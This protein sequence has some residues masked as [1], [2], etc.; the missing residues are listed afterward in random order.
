MKWKNCPLQLYAF[1][2]KSISTNFSWIW[3]FIR[4]PFF[5]LWW[6][7]QQFLPLCDNYK[8]PHIFVVRISQ[9]SYFAPTPPIHILCMYVFSHRT[10]LAFVWKHHFINCYHPSGIKATLKF[11][12]TLI[13]QPFSFTKFVV[14][15]IT[16]A[17][18]YNYG[19]GYL[20]II[21]Y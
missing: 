1:V 2:Y 13:C 11:I 14:Q 20:K 8:I 17:I 6:G 3:A 10:I 19:V 21:D 15:W 9:T 5:N 16:L 12:P 18:F 7:R 4:F